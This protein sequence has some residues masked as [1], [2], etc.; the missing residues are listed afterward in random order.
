LNLRSQSAVLFRVFDNGFERG[1]FV[2]AEAGDQF[3]KDGN[4]LIV[5]AAL[6]K[7]RRDSFAQGQFAGRAERAITSS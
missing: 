2:R 6:A 3:V 5:P 1:V 4:C 7:R